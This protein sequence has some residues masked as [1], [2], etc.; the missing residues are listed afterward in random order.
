MLSRAIETLKDT[1][2][3]YRF[4]L[5]S[6]IFLLALLFYNTSLGFRQQFYHNPVFP[7]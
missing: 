2:S 4:Y 7:E 5:L 6:I 3:E 1:L